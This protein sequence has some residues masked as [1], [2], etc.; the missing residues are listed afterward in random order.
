[1][2]SLNLTWFHWAKYGD[3][4]VEDTVCKL[5]KNPPHFQIVIADLKQ[6]DNLALEYLFTKLPFLS[7]KADSIFCKNLQ[8][9]IES[10]VREATE[11]F[12]NELAHSSYMQGSA[13]KRILQ[14]IIYTGFSIAKLYLMLPEE[15]RVAL[16]SLLP[17]LSAR[18]IKAIKTNEQLSDIFK[19]TNTYNIIRTPVLYQNTLYDFSSVMEY[20]YTQ[21]KTNKTIGLGSSRGDEVDLSLLQLDYKLLVEARKG[22]DLILSEYSLAK[23]LYTTY[24][25]LYLRPA[26]S[27]E[28][29]KWIHDMRTLSVMQRIIYFS[30]VS[31]I[32]VDFYNAIE[33]DMRNKSIFEE[34]LNQSAHWVD[35]SCITKDNILDEARHLELVINMAHKIL[36]LLFNINYVERKSLLQLMSDLIAAPLPYVYAVLMDYILFVP[37]T[38]NIMAW[39]KCV[40]GA[41]DSQAAW[42]PYFIIGFEALLI[43]GILQSGINAFA[44]HE[45]EKLL[46]FRDNLNL[47]LGYI[48]TAKIRN[49]ITQKYLG[50][51]SIDNHNEFEYDKL[52]L[53][54]IATLLLCQLLWTFLCTPTL[55]FAV[56]QF[57]AF[58]NTIDRQTSKNIIVDAQLQEEIF[59]KMNG[60]C[61][62]QNPKI[63]FSEGL[64]FWN[65]SPIP[66][67]VDEKN[68]PILMGNNLSG[69]R[70]LSL[71]TRLKAH[72]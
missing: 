27:G 48:I 60:H 21:K 68:D 29:L 1:M 31:A 7:K 30:V 41:D 19:D 45:F 6:K 9:G 8:S 47:M 44:S 10:K 32:V 20:V 39:N 61:L 50:N 56:D 16:C 18:Q 72:G 53:S 33:L 59:K 12:I 36:S 69:Q 3:K 14:S 13:K 22:A 38:K 70:S 62:A 49:N 23:Y 58:L 54:S 35:L 26:L 17:S 37:M 34:K 25:D 28:F 15:S 65:R 71:G 2:N 66:D 43:N 46:L 52:L 11:E 42:G 63:T 67:E 51:F 40:L 55:N 57:I 4:F 64:F 24:V 5:L